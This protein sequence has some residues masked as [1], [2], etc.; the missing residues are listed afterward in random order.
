MR[1]KAIFLGSI[2]KTLNRIGPVTVAIALALG[3]STVGEEDESSNGTPGGDDIVNDGDPADDGTGVVDG[4][5][6]GGSGSSGS[7]GGEVCNV[8]IL[9][10]YDTSG[11]MMDAVGPLT[12]EAFPGFA[13]A[14]STYPELGNVHVAVTT[15]LWGEQKFQPDQDSPSE[16]TVQTSTFL[17][18][19]WDTSQP[20]DSFWCEEVPSVDCNFSSGN[21]WI[22]GSASSGLTSTMLDEFACVGNVPCQQEVLIGE[23]TLEAGLK[24]LQHPSNAGF[25]R[26]DALL[27]VVYITDEEDQ[28]AMT[29][30]GIRDGLLELKGNDED[31]VV[32]VTIAGPPVGTEEVNS[33]THAKGCV[34]AYGGTEETPGIIAFTEQFGDHGMHYEMCGNNDMSA[35]LSAAFDVLEL[36]CNEIVIN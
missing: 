23:P 33:F 19:G 36:G 2:A 5:G 7:P 34:G 28:S 10:V 26:D 30:A 1:Q 6:D 21:T 16:V 4:G 18:S 25:L 13:T 29:A 24:A 22:E 14:L 27:A 3:C 31:F 32:V 20:H 12:D 11:S 9:F 35:A 8:D 15:N 17:T